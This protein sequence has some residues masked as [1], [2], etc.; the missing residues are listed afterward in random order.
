MTAETGEHTEWIAGVLKEIGAIKSGMTRSDLRKTFTIEGGLYTRTHQTYVHREC[1][2]IKVD[3]KFKPIG[4]EQ[5]KQHAQL[6][7]EILEI[8]RPYLQWTIFD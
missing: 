2:Y 1:P 7:D 6:E 5:D 3:V 4:S 8:S